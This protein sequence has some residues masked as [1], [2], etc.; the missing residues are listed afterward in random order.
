[1]RVGAERMR[2]MR[3][4]AGMSQIELSKKLGVTAQF[5]S[6]WERGMSSI[7]PRLAAKFAKA[8]NADVDEIKGFLVSQYEQRISKLF[9]TRKVK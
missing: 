7:S 5:I 4:S 6:N 3:E 9:R 2:Q 8:T 1:M